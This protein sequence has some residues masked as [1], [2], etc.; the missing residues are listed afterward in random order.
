MKWWP[1]WGNYSFFFT[2]LFTGYILYLE[3]VGIHIVGGCTGKQKIVVG[4]DKGVTNKQTSLCKKRPLIDW[5]K[6]RLVGRKECF[7]RRTFDRTSLNKWTK[8]HLFVAPKSSFRGSRKSQVFLYTSSI[9]DGVDT[10]YCHLEGEMLPLLPT[11]FLNQIPSFQVL[12]ERS[13]MDQTRK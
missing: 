2:W 8:H 12:V 1:K 4:M 9:S 5:Q 11:P 13:H 6:S 10:R 7:F 3:H